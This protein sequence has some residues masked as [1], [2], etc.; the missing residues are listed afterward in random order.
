VNSPTLSASLT[1][2]A[3]EDPRRRLILVVEDSDEQF[4]AVRRAFARAGIPNPVRRC[5]SGDDALDY[6]FQR[7]DHAGPSS[8]PRP[9]LVLLDLNLPGTDGREV[10]DQIKSDADL[11]ILPVVVLSTSSSPGDIER[12]YRNGAASYIVKPVRF[13]DLLA[14]IGHLKAYWIETVALPSSG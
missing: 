4:E 9:G 8:E 7:G 6:L 5:V 12:C 2:I 13:D 14:T 10:L 1:Q 11:R 3:R